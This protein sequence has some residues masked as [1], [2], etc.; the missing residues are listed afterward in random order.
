MK[1]DPFGPTYHVTNSINNVIATIK[2]EGSLEVEIDS[3]GLGYNNG[4]L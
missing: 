3:R 1:L 2:V 4:F